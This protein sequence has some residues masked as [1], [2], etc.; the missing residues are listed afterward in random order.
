MT[1]FTQIAVYITLGGDKMNYQMMLQLV[2]KEHNT[3]PSEVE[4][5]IKEAI[6]AA[7]LDISPQLF[8][9]LCA[10]KVRSEMNAQQ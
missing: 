3:T 10:A 2:A 4:K 7:G 5:E 1:N 8:I 6:K 9:S